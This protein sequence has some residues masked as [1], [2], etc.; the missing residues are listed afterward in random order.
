MLTRIVFL[1]SLFTA[2]TQVNLSAQTAMDAATA[3]TTPSSI[4]NENSLLVHAGV[5]LG[6]YGYAYGT[7]TPILS[8]SL[9]KGMQ[10]L[11]P[12]YIGIGG[13]AGFKTSGYNFGDGYR[14]RYTDILI[15][16][17]GAYHPDFAHS[18]KLDTYGGISLGVDLYNFSSNDGVLDNSSHVNVIYGLY[19]GGRYMFSES[20]GAY[21]ELGYGL[22]YLNLGVV[23]KLK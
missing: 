9:E 15:A 11:G 3:E 7:G 21:G 18:E 1:F 19:F 2:L 6:G 8:V 13:Y 12:G 16:A 23:L 17:R 20:F 4:L 14:W 10:R 5:G 22:G